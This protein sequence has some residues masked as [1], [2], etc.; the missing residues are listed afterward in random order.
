MGINGLDY[1]TVDVR[2]TQGLDT[3]T[4]EKLVIPGKWNQLQNCTL[5]D[6]DTPQRRDGMTALVAAATGNGLAT[7][8][9]ELLVINGAAVSSVSTGG[10]DQT[11]T[12]SG[13]IGNVSVSKQEIRRSTGMQDSNDVA[14]G[15]GYTCYVWRELS[16]DAVQTGL[17]VSVLDETTG[18][19]L[20]ANVLLRTGAT[21]FCPRVV[22]AGNA[23][24]VF[25]IDGTS[26]YCRV[27]QWSAPTTLGAEVALITSASLAALNFDACEFDGASAVVAYGWNDGVTSVRAIT[28]LHVAGVPSIFGGPV[29]L[30]TEAQLAVASL[31]AIA[32]KSYST[33]LFGVFAFNSGGGGGT[34][35]VT[36]DNSYAVVTAATLFL[37]DPP[38]VAGNCTI[39]ATL[40]GG[41]RMQIFTDRRSNWST[42]SIDVIT[43]T[44]VDATI[45]V[46]SGP[47]DVARSASFGGGATDPAGPKG[48]WI[49]GKAFTSGTNVYLPVWTLENY[50]NKNIA[51]ANPRTNNEQNALFVLDC[52]GAGAVGFGFAPVVAKALYGAVG[53]AAINANPPRV[54]SPCSV[55]TLTSGFAYSCT[56]RTLLSLVD[57]FNVSP[58]GVVRLTFTPNASLAPVSVQLGESTY[59][60]GGSMSAYDGA[61]VAEQGF[62]I[63]PEGIDVAVTVGGGSMTAGVHQVVVVAEWIDNGG[64]RAQSAP[65]LA[66][67][68]TTA[69]NDRLVIRCPSLLL[70]QKSEV[71]LVPY[72]TQAAGTTFNRAVALTGSGAGTANN[73]ALAFT[74]LATLTDADATYAANEPLY[75]QPDTTGTTLANIAPGPCNSLAVH[76]NR[77]WY[78]KADQPG[79]FGYSQK[80]VNNLGLQFSPELGGAVDVSGGSIVG[81]STMD[82]KAI[83]FC[84]HKPF[85]VYGSGP[86]SAGNNSGYGVP[87]EIPSD[88]GCSDPRSI[89]KMPHGIIFKSLKGWYLLGRDLQTRYIGEGVA[90]F[91]ANSVSGA[92]LLADRHE[93]RFSS[94]SG[95]QLIYAY[96]NQGGQWS[97]TVYRADSGAAVSNV[98]VADAAWWTTGGYYVTVSLTHGLNQDTAGVFLDQPGSSPS[99]LAIITTA[100][101][102]WLRMSTINGFQRVRKFFLTGTSPNAPTSTLTVTCQFN[103]AYGASV[104]PGSYSF[105]AA[106]GTVFPTFT[107]GTSVD[108]RHSMRTQKCKSVAFTFVDTPTTANPSGVNFQ[109][110]S[111]ELGLKR[112]LKR[113][114]GVQS[115]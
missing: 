16:I 85:V 56:E 7:H 111:L 87:Q 71:V 62:P 110:L 57:G 14:Y 9:K 51:S 79:Q 84:E 5:S 45:V 78:D 1:Q 29:N 97:T 113:L 83:I 112:G 76:Q 22:S 30:Y 17:R 28:T 64:Q 13:K 50:V 67:S 107:V 20:Q 35:G 4:Q 39:T 69:A 108:I 72:I 25:Y 54:S 43:S 98:A 18:T 42:A 103:D 24:F 105:T 12:V 61:A 66:V 102:A 34:W 41:G 80:Y 8:N 90:D 104:D 92:V 63:F 37:P 15:G 60:A 88:V 68:V 101:T 75:T 32:A 99:S 46:Y 3:R 93:C 59:V 10:T 81:F 47:N 94:T 49:A 38:A 55:A 89:L 74:T 48:P 86:D 36:V 52:T 73:T 23:F 19:Q 82:E 11:K 44:V 109:A 115:V 33:T 40:D 2:F 95:T 70:M 26:L 27:V 53:V 91:D 31:S 58:S 6:D 100:R 106:Y 114:P 21:A 96:D 65:C 77:I